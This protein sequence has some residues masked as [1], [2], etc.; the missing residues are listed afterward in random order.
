M[1]G[2]NNNGYYLY[3]AVDMGSTYLQ[4]DQAAM[5]SERTHALNNITTN[6]VTP[7][8]FLL[9]TRIHLPAPMMGSTSLKVS[10]FFE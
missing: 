6:T 5:E 9:K 1:P 10:K 4:A 8:R 2:T 7:N 3:N